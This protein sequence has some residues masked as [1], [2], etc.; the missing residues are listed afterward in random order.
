MKTLVVAFSV[1]ILGVPAIGDDAADRAKLVGTWQLEHGNEKDGSV[2]ILE[3]KSDAIRIVHSQNNQK[4][5]D[6]ECNTVGRD[7]D[8]TDAGHHHAKVSMWFNGPKLVQ[9]ETRGSEVVKYR[10][11]V[12]GEGNTME[13]EVIPIVPAGTTEILQFRR[14]LLSASQK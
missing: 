12:T 13:V 2:W 4:L 5:V 11:A 6:F 1:L 3:S 8:V 10:I 9:Y 14:V 7:C